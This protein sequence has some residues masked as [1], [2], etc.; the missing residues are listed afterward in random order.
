MFRRVIMAVGLAVLL[1]GFAS[2]QRGGGG[3]GGGGGGGG[4]FGGRAQAADKLETLTKEFKLTAQ[5]Q[6]E[7]EAIFNESQKQ[8]TEIAAKA[9]DEKNNLLKLT[10]AGKADDAEVKK[11]ADLNSQVIMVGIDAYNKA[12]AKLDDKQKTKASK[13]YQMVAGMFGGGNWRRST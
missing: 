3:R 12:L 7:L 8:A 6:T 2:A 1:A 11:M 5:Q 13:F 4:G 9:A 10:V